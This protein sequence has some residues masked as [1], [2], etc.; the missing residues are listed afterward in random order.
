MEQNIGLS[1]FFSSLN[2]IGNTLSAVVLI[3]E[4]DRI[5]R[6]KPTSKVRNA[7]TLALNLII[8]GITLV[9]GM[10]APL[11]DIFSNNNAASLRL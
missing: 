6:G 10:V 8:Q 1:L 3:V 2:G 11:S 5:H 7:A 4:D 9:F